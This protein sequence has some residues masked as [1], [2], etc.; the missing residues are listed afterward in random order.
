[1][2]G[3]QAPFFARKELAHIL[4]L[5][6]PNVRIRS[7]FIGGGFGG[8]SQCP[9]PIALAALLSLKTERPVKIVL[10]RKEEFLG[11][12][13]DHA[14]SMTVVTGAAADGRL[15]A[16]RTD[17]TVDNGAFTHMGPAYVS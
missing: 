2:A 13:T 14:K 9:E 3:T 15:L 6:L 8:K 16:R 10:S 7:T 4:D 5:P 11:G 12:K 17:F 1:W